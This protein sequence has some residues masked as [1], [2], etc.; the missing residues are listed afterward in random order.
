MVPLSVL[1]W[2]V[3]PLEKQFKPPD[4][5]HSCSVHAIYLGLHTDIQNGGWAGLEIK[6]DFHEGAVFIPTLLAIYR[7]RLARSLSLAWCFLYLLVLIFCRSNGGKFDGDCVLEYIPHQ[8]R[9]V[10]LTCPTL[11]W[12]GRGFILL[13]VSMIVGLA[14]SESRLGFRSLFR[15]VFIGVQ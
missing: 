14:A 9:F 7:Y 3:L 13:P 4:S 1:W 10:K 6:V 8:W 15:V 5:W 11:A 12:S 2:S